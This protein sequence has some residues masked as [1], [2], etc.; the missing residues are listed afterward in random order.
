MPYQE[1]HD[2]TLTALDSHEWKYQYRANSIFDPNFTGVGHYP[3]GYLDWTELYRK[4]TVMNTYLKLDVEVMA[5]EGVLNTSS[6]Q[7]GVGVT[8]QAQ[9]NYYRDMDKQTRMEHP[10]SVWKSLAVN[11]GSSKSKKTLTYRWNA[12]RFFGRNV[13]TERDYTVDYDKDPFQ[14]ASALFTLWVQDE[15]AGWVEGDSIVL[16]ARL[17]YD[18]I[19]RDPRLFNGS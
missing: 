16:T 3:F 6:I 7:F 8:N 1:V 19:L 12:S 15:R 17:V 11:S 9:A 2:F 5:S 4:Y 14:Y 13:L 18:V 10:R